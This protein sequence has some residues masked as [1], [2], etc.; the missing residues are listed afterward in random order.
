MKPLTG[1]LAIALLA[2]GAGGYYYTEVLDKPAQK[3]PTAKKQQ[4]KG[5]QAKKKKAKKKKA[6]AQAPKVESALPQDILTAVDTG[7]YLAVKQALVSRLKGKDITPA[8]KATQQ[9]TML[10]EFIRETGANTLS[11]FAAAGKDKQAF[12]SAFARDPEWQELYLGAGLVPYQTDVGIDVLY[13]IWRDEEKNVQN[14]K[15]A[16]ALASVWGGGET[17]PNPP[18]RKRNPET[19]N[20]VWRYNFFQEQAEKGKLHPNYK[21]LRPWELRFTVAIPEQDWDDASFTWAAENIN[22]PWDRYYWACWA[23]VYTDPSKFGDDV[24]SGEYGLP[25][26]EESA[27]QSTHV[28]GGVCGA[29]SHLGCFAAMAHGIPSYTVGQPGHCAYGL[30][31]E[32]GKWV[33]GFGG[34][35]GGLHNHIFGKVAPTSY[36]LMESVFADDATIDKAYRE[37]WCARALEATGDAAGAEKMW[38]QALA[39]SPLHPFFRTQLHRLMQERGA[40]A[41][42]VFDYLKEVIPAYKGNGMAAA[43]MVASLEPVVATMS[44]KQ[45]LALYDAMHAAIATTPSS[46]AINME[47]LFNKQAASLDDDKAR[48]QYMASLFSTYINA[49]DATVFGKALEWAVKEYVQKGK[50]EVF[51]QAFVKATQSASSASLGGNDEA[52]KNAMLA[53]YNKAILAAE[54]ARSIPAFQ[55]L[56]DAAEKAFGVFP[57][58]NKLENADKLRGKPAPATG[59]IRICST[60]QWDKPYAHRNLMTLEGGYCHSGS[61]QKPDYVVE[62]EKPATLTGCIIR[63]AN[64]SED[65]MKKATVYTSADGA[66][67]MKKAEIDNMPKEWVVEFPKGTEGKWVKLEF[68]NSPG[69]NFSHLTHFVVYTK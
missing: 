14:K 35:D 46:W 41:D 23:A 11:T 61:E 63:K 40:T 7:D 30:R 26:Y 32:R 65:R 38:K 68:D 44:D 24:Q 25:F 8:D 42:E 51:G 47:E 1:I 43:D 53:S 3:A 22:L 48:E 56:V 18:L 15:L 55:M 31:T 17:E 33:G 52:R 60:N 9:A 69:S 64:G 16:V 28:N 67:W 34:P 50:A 37:S 62:L 57:E 29:M 27:A 13:R 59:L 5:K 36:L 39:T 20:P 6:V 4:V 54:Q 12:L 19:N 45:K 21:N 66:T 49:T 10:L 2:L 58:R